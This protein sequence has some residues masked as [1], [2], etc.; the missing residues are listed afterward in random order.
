MIRRKI[1]SL[2]P[3]LYFYQKIFLIKI[4]LISVVLVLFSCS[5]NRSDTTI[6]SQEL[7]AVQEYYNFSK[8]D[9]LFPTEN[10]KWI[11]KALLLASKLKADMTIDKI[12]YQKNRLHLELREYDSLVFYDKYLIKQAKKVDDRLIFAYQNYLMGYY[13]EKIV[14]IPDSAFVRY[15]RSKTYYQQLNDSIWI[16]KNL[17]NM[18][19]IQ[20]TQSDFFGSKE[21]LTEALQYLDE[22]NKNDIASA[23]NTLGTNHR[24]LYNYQDAE[25]YF[26]KAI[27]LTES[28]ENRLGIKNNQAVNYLDNGEFTRAAKLLKEIVE[29]SLLNRKSSQYARVLDNLAYAIW[30]SDKP[31]NKESFFKSLNLRKQ[32]NDKRGMISSYTHLGEFYSKTEPQRAEAYFD[33]VIQLS[34]TIRAPRAE[35]EVLRDLINMYPNRIGLRDRYDFLQD[36]LYTRELKVKTQFAKYKYDDR[37]KQESILRLE[38][39][40]AEQELEATR[41]RNFK[42]ALFVGVLGLIFLIIIGYFIYQQRLKHLKAQNRA[43][44]ME[45]AYQTE[46]L[47]S[48]RLHDDFGAGINHVM[49]LIQSKADAS[50]ILDELDILYQQSRDFSREINAVNTG[51]G[52]KDELIGMLDLHKP[53]EIRLIISG[54]KDILWERIGSMSKVT[55]Y[56]VLRELFINMTKHSQATTVTLNFRQDSENIEVRYSD[57]GIGV[58]KNKKI[59]KNGLQNTEKRI[60]AIGGTITFESEQGNGFKA[61]ILIPN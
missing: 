30:L 59:V 6:R 3:F 49:L 7:E 31:I 58:S 41:E 29:D 8:S 11:N 38:K 23:F 55:L 51:A 13:Y 48:R 15:S 37:L 27:A 1:I 36:S 46:T 12:L 17:L 54:S 56:K 22:E 16:G 50:K 28:D 18:A 2:P 52:Y 57:N 33:T 45:A 21:T 5:G 19:N 35:K 20:Q 34:K 60:E 40:K 14:G 61:L 39:E 25:K 4:L 32:A 47:L 53:Q 42:R 26:L 44:R 10:K 24:K 43:D 9:S